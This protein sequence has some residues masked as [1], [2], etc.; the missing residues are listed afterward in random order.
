[1]SGNYKC[2]DDQHIIDVITQNSPCK[3]SEI[4]AWV[5][6]DKMSQV[7]LRRRLESLHRDGHIGYFGKGKG[8]YYFVGDPLVTNPYSVAI[9]ASEY[10]E[11]EDIAELLF[12]ELKQCTEPERISKL[13]EMVS[14]KQDLVAEEAFLNQYK[15]RS[16]QVSIQGY[17]KKLGA[18]MFSGDKW[19]VPGHHEIVKKVDWKYCPHCGVSL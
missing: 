6:M 7:V 4:C 13:N 10:I 2:E 16:R 8:R 12:D 5:D 9:H 11:N 17:M 14:K 15:N 3:I 18:T 19:Y 1:M